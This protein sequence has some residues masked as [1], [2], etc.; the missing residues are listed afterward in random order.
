MARRI[1][2]SCSCEENRPC[3]HEL[4]FIEKQKHCNYCNEIK[5]SS[6]HCSGKNAYNYGFK[7]GVEENGRNTKNSI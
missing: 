5:S 3:S 6:H 2:F 1:K 4:A 7:M